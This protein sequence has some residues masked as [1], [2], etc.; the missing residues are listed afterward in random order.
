MT[1]SIALS[2]GLLT[3]ECWKSLRAKDTTNEKFAV[4]MLQLTYNVIEKK[5]M[6]LLYG[7]CFGPNSS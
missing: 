1:M 3:M 2:I 4:E 6:E 5:D 7:K